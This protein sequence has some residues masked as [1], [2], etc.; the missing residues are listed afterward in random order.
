M[1]DQT[2]THYFPWDNTDDLAYCGHRMRAADVH[3]P[4][5]TCPACAARQAAEEGAIDETA[6]PLDADEARTELDPVL[7]AGVPAPSPVVAELF[8]W[9]VDLTRSYAATV[10]RSGDDTLAAH[11]LGECEHGCAFCDDVTALRA[12]LVQLYGMTRPNHDRIEDIVDRLTAIG[13]TE[14][15]VDAARDAETAT[16]A[17]RDEAV[18]R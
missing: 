1:L 9:A 18:C 2:V 13:E 3:S 14:A 17:R 8:D 15:I 4:Q 7:N 5:P 12:E 16:D 11:R 10:R 6:L